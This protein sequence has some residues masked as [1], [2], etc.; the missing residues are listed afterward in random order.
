MD[1]INQSPDEFASKRELLE[2]LVSAHLSI[3]RKGLGAGRVW[4]RWTK[5]YSPRIH[6]CQ[7]ACR[8][9]APRAQNKLKPSPTRTCVNVGKENVVHPNIWILL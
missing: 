2:T 6:Q 1:L 5:P 4:I 8:S 9:A 3:G 7:E